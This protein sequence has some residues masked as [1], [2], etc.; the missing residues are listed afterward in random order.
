MIKDSDK[1][2]KELIELTKKGNLAFDEI[3][4]LNRAKSIVNH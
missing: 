3:S 1:I 2:R 4:L